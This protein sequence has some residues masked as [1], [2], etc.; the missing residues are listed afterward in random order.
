[1]KKKYTWYELSADALRRAHAQYRRNYEVDSDV[2]V[3]A[4]IK[5]CDAF[6]M[7]LDAVLLSPSDSDA[8]KVYAY[9]ADADDEAM[10][11]DRFERRATAEMRLWWDVFSAERKVSAPPKELAIAFCEWLVDL[12]HCRRIEYEKSMLGFTNW[13]ME[14]YPETR[15]FDKNGHYEITE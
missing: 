13:L 5:A 6:G 14:Y 11:I 15:M 2:A 10:A 8:T 1:M 7:S 12:F 4:V 9:F 3:A